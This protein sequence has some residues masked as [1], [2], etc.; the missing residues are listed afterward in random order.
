MLSFSSPVLGSVD[1]SLYY[2]SPPFPPNLCRCTTEVQSSTRP[3]TAIFASTIFG[4]CPRDLFESAVSDSD[5]CTYLSQEKHI[6]DL[7][8]KNQE[9][10][11]FKFVLDYR[12]EEFKK[13]IE[14]REKDIKTMKEQIHDVS[15]TLIWPLLLSPLSQYKDDPASPMEDSTLFVP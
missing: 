4:P 14:S 15:N 6:Y 3:V 11:K 5:L 1:G 13:Q 9:L 2:L 12:I 10:E 8:K 7:K